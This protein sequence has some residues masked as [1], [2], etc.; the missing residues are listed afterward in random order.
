MSLTIPFMK[1][2]AFSFMLNKQKYT[3]WSQYYVYDTY[4]T[5]F[6]TVSPI[7]KCYL[8]KKIMIRIKKDVL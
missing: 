7:G 3:L 1:K 4:K 5:L 2:S 8:A 6:D